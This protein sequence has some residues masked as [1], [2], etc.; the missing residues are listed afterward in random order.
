MDQSTKYAQLLRAIGQA[1]EVL[2]FGS[3]EMT[4]EREGVQVRGSVHSGEEQQKARAIRKNLVRYVWDAVPTTSVSD[5]EMELALASWPT[6][7]ELRYTPKD[8]YRLDE[9][10][11]KQRQN[12]PAVTDVAR[13]S[14]LLRTIGSYVETKSGRLVKITRQEDSL[15]IEYETADGEKHEE[16][17]SAA[18]LYDFWVL[19]YL[20]RK[21]R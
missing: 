15:H 12:P 16:T 14:Q 18:S 10:G 13:L 11:K 21:D 1:L 6:Q 3:F 2:N 4:F 17:V 20:R 19:T 9:E 8:F 5:D 7:M